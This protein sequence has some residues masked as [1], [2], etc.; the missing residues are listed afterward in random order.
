M[1]LVQNPNLTRFSIGSAIFLGAC[2]VIQF[3][4]NWQLRAQ[5]TSLQTVARECRGS[6]ADNAA[7]L[8]GLKQL[9]SGKTATNVEQP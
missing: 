3:A 9:T 8:S 5:I 2:C 4:T 6:E 1:K 7:V